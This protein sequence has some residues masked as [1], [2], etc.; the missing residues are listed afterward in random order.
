[1]DADARAIETIEAYFRAFR[2]RDRA[3]LER[4][5][6]PDLRHVSPFGT[7][8]A[9]DTML[10]T[11]W[12]Q[13]G[14]IWVLELA[15]YG[16]HPEFLAHYRHG[17]ASDAHLAERFRFNGDRIVEVEVYLG[18]GAVPGPTSS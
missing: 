13:L 14:P 15:I 11:V 9:R 1:M 7:Q 2:E 12:P 17:G 6:V 10:D 3:T 16:R 8:T 4:I 18:L 5:L